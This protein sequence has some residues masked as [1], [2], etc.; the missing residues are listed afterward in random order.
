[1]VGGSDYLVR[2]MF[3]SLSAI[4]SCWRQTCLCNSQNDI[5]PSFMT[6]T[7]LRAFAW[8]LGDEPSLGEGQGLG[9]WEGAVNFL[10]VMSAFG[11]LSLMNMMKS[12]FSDHHL[13]TSLCNFDAAA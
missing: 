13:K 8:S 9:W 5:Q 12:K 2:V 1:M 11:F 4:H 7:S 3:S 10:R 6:V